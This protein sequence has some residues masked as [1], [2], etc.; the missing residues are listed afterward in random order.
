MYVKLNLYSDI[1]FND[2]KVLFYYYYSVFVIKIY[3]DCIALLTLVS[4][5][6]WPKLDHGFNKLIKLAL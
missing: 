5:N 2:Y 3:V 1:L 6:G 4:Y